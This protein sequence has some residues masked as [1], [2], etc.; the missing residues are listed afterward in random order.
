MLKL[1]KII[2]TIFVFIFTM[3]IICFVVSLVNFFLGKFEANQIVGKIGLYFLYTIGYGALEGDAIIQNILAIIGIVSLALMSTFLTINLFWRLDDVN[4]KKRIVFKKNKKDKNLIF[5]F[6]NKGRTI[7]DMKVVFMVHDSTSGVSNEDKREFY[8]PILFKKSKW[9]ISV[10]I[11][12]SFW[13]KAMYSLFINPNLKLYCM[14]SF[15]DTKNGQGSIKVEEVTKE[16][17]NYPENNLTLEYFIKPITLRHD[18]MKSVS[19]G[20]AVASNYYQEFNYSFKKQALP[21]DFVMAY[22]DFNSNNLDLEKYGK[23]KVSLEFTLSADKKVTVTFEIKTNS[24]CAYTLEIPV[25]TKHKK[26]LIP[27]NDIS[28]NLEN[29]NEMCFTVFKKNSSNEN[30]LYISDLIIHRDGK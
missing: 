25:T 14:Y 18:T 15:V 12:E 11:E 30:K 24:I 8:L 19:N 7:C 16:F 1:R 9:A 28:N 27:L 3:L 17:L 2:E 29:I 26:I 13:Y 22:H 4:M 21:Y 20:A 10:D 6:Q 23:D 5:E